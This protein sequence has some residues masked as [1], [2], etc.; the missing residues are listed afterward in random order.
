MSNYQNEDVT[1]NI[2]KDYQG[3]VYINVASTKKI[4]INALESSYTNEKQKDSGKLFEF[5]Y[6]G[7]IVRLH[8]VRLIIGII[9]LLII[10]FF[11]SGILLM[12][13]VT[14]CI[15]INIGYDFSRATE[16][17]FFFLAVAFYF[18]IGSLVSITLSLWKTY[19][20]IIYSIINYKYHK[21]D[22]DSALNNFYKKLWNNFKN[23]K[24]VKCILKYI[25]KSMELRVTLMLILII[26]LICITI[27]L[28][29]NHGLFVIINYLFCILVL[30]GAISLIFLNIIAKINNFIIYF[31]KFPDQ[32]ESMNKCYKNEIKQKE[33][34][35]E[36][37][38]FISYC[39]V[40]GMKCRQRNMTEFLLNLLN[41]ILFYIFLL[42]LLCVRNFKAKNNKLL[43]GLGISLLV[44]N[45]LVK[46]P[47]KYW[48]TIVNI[49]RIIVHK[50][51]E[52]TDQGDKRDGRNE[53]GDD[54]RLNEKLHKR[55]DKEKN[56]YDYMSTPLYWAT[57]MGLKIIEI[58]ICLYSIYSL[59]NERNKE[60]TKDKYFLICFFLFFIFKES[61]YILC[62]IYINSKKISKKFIEIFFKFFYAVIIFFGTI[63]ILLMAFIIISDK[64]IKWSIILKIFCEF[65]FYPDP[66]HTW[67]N[68]QDNTV[69][70]NI[71]KEDEFYSVP[72]IPDIKSEEDNYTEESP[73]ILTEEYINNLNNSSNN[74]EVKNRLKKL[75][76]HKNNLNIF[77]K[78]NVKKQNKKKSNFLFI[79]SFLILFL[80]IWGVV[81]VIVEL[82]FTESESEGNQ[83]I[84]E[85]FNKMN[86]N[87]DINEI[88]E[89]NTNDNDMNIN[90][91][92]TSENYPAICYYDFD[93][94]SI[95]DFSILASASYANSTTNAKN[96]W[97]YGRPLFNVDCN[98]QDY[99]FENFVRKEVDMIYFTSKCKC[100]TEHSNWNS[101][102]LPEIS[103]D[104]NRYNAT[105]KCSYA[106]SSSNQ[107]NTNDFDN[108]LLNDIGENFICKKQMN[109]YNEKDQY[110]DDQSDFYCTPTLNNSEN[111]L[112]IEDCSCVL[113]N[114][115]LIGNN[116]IDK[117]VGVQYVDFEF[118]NK[119]IIVIGVRGTTVVEDIIQDIYIW[120]ASVL[121]QVSGSF[122]TFTNLWPRSAISWI[123]KQ[124]DIEFAVKDNDLLYYKDV[125]SHINDLRNN[126]NKTG[127]KFYL[128][129]HSLGGGV[130]GIVSS[131]LGIPAVTFS[132]P[133][134]GYSYESYNITLKGL[135]DN[136]VNI[137]PL[138]DVV[139]LFDSQVGQIQYITCNKNKVLECHFLK[140][141]IN[142]LNNM[143]STNST[144]SMLLKNLNKFV[145]SKYLSQI[146]GD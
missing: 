47:I 43:I 144:N 113:D 104:S 75:E 57:V 85:E 46:F 64:F 109:K 97:K 132:A 71:I 79:F 27:Y 130:A 32:L 139:P 53:K 87:N 63:I 117:D 7:P 122:G 49:S 34:D 11:T 65:K 51:K 123:I 3:L 143:C 136:F 4:N 76:E 80:F 141:T 29:S 22:E 37:H 145:D 102:K 118:P 50:D 52:K 9:K 59:S 44:L 24:Y 112:E 56:N 72:D 99:K 69:F 96:I 119:K 78:R 131:S 133:G 110:N 30:L 67:S 14:V 115:F 8:R 33:K 17:C 19:L 45:I 31:N 20:K 39:N 90:N 137:V 60:K 107:I 82:F 142:T 146:I 25:N 21:K 128:T 108:V 35:K 91:N 68:E 12:N 70:L 58:L 81:A 105:C 135:I 73:N 92:I 18:Y 5:N 140:N 38:I 124:I 15:I 121:I 48:D 126:T 127:Y 98:C 100:N 28:V 36:S 84:P 89:W 138:K 103:Q 125:I 42:R 66:R 86:I 116:T 129:G 134:L 101:K 88:Y 106:L 120:C 10:L 62:Y 74:E 55:K 54:Y 23:L 16:I 94:F 6:N 1:F 2:Y 41:R 83:S 13:M 114:Y 93:G 111:N 40:N 26:I 61:F 95:N 77:M